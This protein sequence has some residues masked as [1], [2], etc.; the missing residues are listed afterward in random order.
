MVILLGRPPKV[1]VPA[2]V[3]GTQVKPDRSLTRIALL[4]AAVAVV[5]TPFCLSSPATAQVPRGFEAVAE[6]DCLILYINSDTAEIAVTDKRSGDIWHS[7]PPDRDKVEKI[8][9]GDGKLA[10]GAQFRLT[11]YEPGDVVRTVDSFVSSVAH[12]QFEIEQ[13]ENGV[14]V[15]Y[16]VGKQWADRD[17]LP[18]FLS[19]DTFENE[20]L[21]KITDSRTRRTIEGFYVLLT[22]EKSTGEGASIAGYSLMSPGT[23]LRDRDQRTLT[24][25]MID[26]IVLNTSSLR[27]RNDIKE[28]TLAPF[29]DTEFYM[30]KQRE[31]DLLAWD[32]EDIVAVMKDIELDPNVISDH[33]VRLGIDPRVQNI[34]VFHVPVE[35][36]LDGDNLVVRVPASEIRYPED[37]LD[38]E[39]Q[40]VTYPLVSIDVLPYFGAA[41]MTADGYM[42]VPDGSGALI[43]LN[44]NKTGLNAYAGRVYGR[45]NALSPPPASLDSKLCSFPVYGLKAGDKAFLGIIEAGDALAQIAAD[46]AG[47]RESYNTICAQFRL[48]GHATT[49]LQGEVDATHRESAQWVY[50]RTTINVYQEDMYAGDIQVRYAFLHGEDA[51]YQG[52]ARYYQDYLVSRGRMT[53]LSPRDGAPLYV[54]LIGAVTDY[55]PVLGVPREIVVPLTT[56]RQAKDIASRIAAQGIGDIRLVYS[57]W[58]QYG[59]SHVYPTGVKLEKALGSKSDLFAL[60]DYMDSIGGQLYPS[61][62]FVMVYRADLFTGFRPWRDASRFLNRTEAFYPIVYA[63]RANPANRSPWSV[64]VLSPSRLDNLVSRYL[65]DYAEYGFSGLALGDLAF[66]LHSD[67]RHRQTID[68]QA[69]LSIVEAQITKAKD[70]YSLRLLAVGANAYAIPYVDDILCLPMTCGGQDIIDEAVPFMQ[71]VL[72]G[73]FDYAGDPA[74]FAPDRD[75]YL[76]KLLETGS[77]PYFLGYYADSSVLKGSAFDYLYT[78]QFEKW[79]EDAA[80]LYATADAVLGRVQSQRIV[81]HR[82]LAEN[83]Y[84][85]CYEDGTSVVVN[86]GDSAVTVKGQEVGPLGFVVLED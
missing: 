70:D 51:G 16:V 56:Y 79:L 45:D 41:D 35:Y 63:Q 32:L 9:R 67:F 33:Y 65:K 68:R 66:Q 27:D 34:V 86:Y 62:D 2:V 3:G 52:M 49:S 18:L 46:I 7:N 77:A 43:R 1:L 85:T 4:M 58:M 78:G 76:L 23:T 26:H 73:Y 29:I 59:I 14:R 8:A 64:Y 24:E 21:G 72:H 83:V 75:H 38:S 60:R 28:S 30:L 54:E 80:A 25:V 37:V 13:I 81:D 31:R 12:N 57:G 40:K 19:K 36:T 15:S 69:T 39:G 84:Q 50:G 82:K 53:R 20:I 42:F 71:L 48:L 61:V 11:Y 55:R 74:N 6:N 47:K 22:L 17:F 10:L 5:L 44:N